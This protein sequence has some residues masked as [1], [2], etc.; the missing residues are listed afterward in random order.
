MD[1]VAL[2]HEQTKCAN[3]PIH[4]VP[5]FLCNETSATIIEKDVYGI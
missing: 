1:W 5:T 2:I 3:L 4:S